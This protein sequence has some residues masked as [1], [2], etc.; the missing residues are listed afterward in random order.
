MTPEDWKTQEARWLVR[1]N[2]P[3]SPVRE[4]RSR[5]QAMDAAQRAVLRKPDYVVSVYVEMQRV[6]GGD[7][8]VLELP[9]NKS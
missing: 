6:T 8:V 4:Y 7:P 2:Y 3:K 1:G 5:E 9:Q